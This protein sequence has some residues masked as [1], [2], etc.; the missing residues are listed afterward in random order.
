MRSWVPAA[1]N[2]EGYDG[3]EKEES[4][5]RKTNTINSQITDQ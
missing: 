4:G 5:H 3:H 2:F 1:L